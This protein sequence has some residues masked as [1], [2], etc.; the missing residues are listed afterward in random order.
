MNLKKLSLM[1]TMILTSRSVMKFSVS[2]LKCSVF[3]WNTRNVADI[4]LGVPWEFQTNETVFSTQIR[5]H[6]VKYPALGNSHTSA[7]SQASS[8]SPFF[9]WRWT[10]LPWRKFTPPLA[11]SYT[12]LI[13]H[14]KRYLCH[15]FSLLLWSPRLRWSLFKKSTFSTFLMTDD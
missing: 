11:L 10:F 8:H 5:L 1:T 13:L 2:T 14:N 7:I 3:F 15:L 9:Q 12:W 6:I 4:G